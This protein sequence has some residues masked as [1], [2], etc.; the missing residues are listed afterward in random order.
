MLG[1]QLFKHL[2]TRYDARVTLRRDLA[3]YKD[4]ELFSD[5]S[6]YTWI[7]VRNAER[8]ID[9]FG[10]FHPHAVVNAVGAVKQRTAGK[11][12]VS[13][14]EINALFPHR[15]AALCKAMDLRLVHVSTDCVFSGKRGNYNENDLADPEDLYGR[16]KLLGEVHESNCL[17]L[18]TSMIGRELLHKK[19]L[20]EWFL[21]QSERIKGFKR[22]IFSG[23]TTIELSRIIERMLV[24]YPYA[25][26]VYHVSSEPISKFDLLMAIKAALELSVEIIPDEEV[27]CDRSLDSTRFRGEFDYKPPAWKSMIDELANDVRQEKG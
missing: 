8:L 13:N 26:G 3:V 10:D 27:R 19:S 4:F 2:R 20:L 9:V 24:E 11:E 16:S 15:L 1:H 25:S 6:A 17:T 12:E 22:A 18:R 7:D 21:A 5:K 23:F 14:L